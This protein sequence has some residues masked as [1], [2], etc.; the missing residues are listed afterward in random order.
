MQETSPRIRF[1]SP[2]KGGLVD[3]TQSTGASKSR[4]RLEQALD[5]DLPQGF[6]KLIWLQRARAKELLERRPV[7]RASGAMS[8]SD[9]RQALLSSTLRSYHDFSRAVRR[10]REAEAVGTASSDE[11]YLTRRFRDLEDEIASSARPASP[12]RARRAALFDDRPALSGRLKYSPVKAPL[13]A[14]PRT[15]LSRTSARRMM[16]ELTVETRIAELHEELLQW[17]ARVHDLQLLLSRHDPLPTYEARPASVA[18]GGG[19]P[20]WPSLHASLTR[21]LGAPAPAPYPLSASYSSP[22]SPSATAFPTAYAYPAAPRPVLYAPAP[23]PVGVGPSL[24]YPM[25]VPMAVPAAP[26]YVSY[27]M[28]GSPHAVYA[29]PAPAPAAGPAPTPVYY[30]AAPGPSLSFAAASPYVSTAAAAA[31]R[32]PS[33]APADGSPLQASFAGAYSPGPTLSPSFGAPACAAGAAGTGFAAR[34]ADSLLR[35]S[36]ASGRPACPRRRRAPARRSAPRRPSSSPAP[37]R[38]G[39]GRRLGPASSGAASLSAPPPLHPP[40]LQRP[41]TAGSA[42]VLLSP[43]AGAD[44]FG[45]SAAAGGPRARGELAPLSFSASGSDASWARSSLSAIRTPGSVLPRTPGAPAACGRAPAP[46]L[47]GAGNGRPAQLHGSRYGGAW[48]SRR[49]RPGAPRPRAGAGDGG[50]ARGGRGGGRVAD[51]AGGDGGA[52]WDEEEEE[53]ELD[54]QREALKRSDEDIHRLLDRMAAAMVRPPPGPL[55]P[56]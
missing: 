46:L 10:E 33:L 31:P 25:T 50:G 41:D 53:R 8:G 2:E 12:S 15:S 55:S 52:A 27:A 16:D 49:R 40:P 1:S 34:H 48:R 6:E 29:A 4:T 26:S 38:R 47:E 11:A 14:P 3:V 32:G 43:S 42:S 45:S 22:T 18:S 35:S 20:L 9:Y 24:S 39:P 17:R 28:P 51:G 56:T 54:A 21:P 44:P 36:F 30:A 7:D 13:S 19:W 23:S 37:A 5:P